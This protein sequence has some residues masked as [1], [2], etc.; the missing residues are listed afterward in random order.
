MELFLYMTSLMKIHFKRYAQEV[1]ALH[2]QT[3][4]KQN[5]GVEE[6]FLELTRRMLENAVTNDQQRIN[7]LT[8]GGN[9]RNLQ[10]VDDQ[11]TTPTQKSS[12]CSS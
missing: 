6:L 11:V 4:A 12:C 8:R 5:K 9:T 2:F 10:L 1:G 7:T 3:S